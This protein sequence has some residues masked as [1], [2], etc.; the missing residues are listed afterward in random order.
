MTKVRYILARKSVIISLVLVVVAVAVVVYAQRPATDTPTTMLVFPG[1]FV[2]QVSI[3]G[4]VTAEQSANLGFDQSGRVAKIFVSV[5]DTVTE[6][7]SIA[8]LANADLKADIAQKEAVLE[9]EKAKLSS[10]IEGTRPEE[11]YQYSQRFT[12]ASSALILALRTAYFQT[13][14]AILNKADIVFT[15]ADTV[16]P[17]LNVRTDSENQKR[18]IELDRLLLKESMFTWKNSLPELSATSTAT[19]ET[20]KTQALSTLST[21]KAFLDNLGY[22]VSLI[23]PSNSAYTQTQIDTIRS[24]VNSASMTI[25][26]AASTEQTAY[27]TWNSA[28]TALNLYQSGSRIADV[29]AQSATVRSAEAD[30]ETSKARLAKT[31]ITAPFSGIITKTDIKV[32]EIVSPSDAPFS[33]MSQGQFE[34]ESFIPEINISSIKIGDPATV[35]LDAYGDQV[36]FLAKVL[37]I[38]PAETIRDAVSTYK[39]KLKFDE[40]DARIRS[41]MTANVVVTTDKR[42]NIISIPQGI[43]SVRDGKSF[44]TVVQGDSVREVEIQ[45]GTTSS[46]GQVEIISGLNSG[47]TISLNAPATK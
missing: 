13:E 9:R 39:V 33:I 37:T 31:T 38:D 46:T 7:M 41:G 3:S 11:L 10:V 17:T 34:I 44:V 4:K 45:T 42:D 36:V 18:R 8:S 16:N 29:V 6:D 43:I 28:K 14:D 26:T 20:A 47:D 2:S 19:L 32:G 30:I 23:S 27:T 25:A 1:T 12:D 5:G 15:N 21:A 35:T 22:T 40:E 24:A